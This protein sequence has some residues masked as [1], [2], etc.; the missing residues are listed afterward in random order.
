MAVIN[1]VCKKCGKG[2]KEGKD[3]PCEPLKVLLN[4]YAETRNK[5]RYQLIK[6]FNK[7]LNLIDAEPSKEL[8]MLADRIINKFDDLHFI[9]DLNIKVGYVMSQE[10]KQGQKTVYADCRRVTTVYSAYLPYDFIIT[11]YESSV[12]MLSENQKKIL[13]RHELQHIECGSRGLTVRLH[14]I[15]DF[16]NILEEYGIKWNG[17]DESVPDILEE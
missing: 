8:R 17:F 15:E 13:M 9:K 16:S 10:R 11:F 3:D 5:E 2:C 7:D 1:L 14:D 4:I 6:K 12:S